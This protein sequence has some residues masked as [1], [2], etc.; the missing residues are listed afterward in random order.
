MQ[1]QFERKFQKKMM[2][3]HPGE[4]LATKDDIILSTLLGSCVAACLYDPVNRVVGMNHFLLA[5]NF[6]QNDKYFLSEAGRYGINAMELLINEMMKL[7]AKRN[8]LKAKVFGGAH[9]LHNVAS[10]PGTVPETNVRFIK[11]F[12]YTENIEIIAS[13]LGGSYGRKVLFFVEDFKVLMKRL[14]SQAAKATQQE[15]SQYLAKQKTSQRIKTDQKS[16]TVDFFE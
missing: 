15:E 10:G 11:T 13:D 4:Y 9:V 2:I 3:L 8:F 1:E 16:G 14:D 12:L 5:G 6:D 7:G